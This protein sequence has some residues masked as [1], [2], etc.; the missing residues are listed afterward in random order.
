MRSASWLVQ[1][2]GAAK[3]PLTR[4][5]AF[6]IR[7]DPGVTPV[8]TDAHGALVAAKKTWGKGCVLLFADDYSYWDFNSYPQVKQRP[9][10]INDATTAA[11]FLCL[12]WKNAWRLEHNY[13]GDLKAS[14]VETITQP[15][16]HLGP[17]KVSTEPLHLTGNV[18]RHGYL[19]I[20]PQT[21]TN[22]ATLTRRI[23]VPATGATQIYLGGMRR[24]GGS[25]VFLSFKID[26]VQVWKK[27]LL[28]D[29]IPFHEG[30][31][32]SPYAGQAITL[33]LSADTQGEWG[34]REALLDYVT[35]LHTP[36]GGGKTV[37]L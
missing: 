25:R 18:P 16:V 33:C 23:D 34:C 3:E 31:D 13:T 10:P 2:Y 20:H 5:I 15:P 32:L 17:L 36:P 24:I 28:R 27:P 12:D 11:I 35:I 6:T 30:I 26:S 8:L 29:M 21:P 37:V 4:N 9:S 1:R 14:W 22:P 19:V 7:S